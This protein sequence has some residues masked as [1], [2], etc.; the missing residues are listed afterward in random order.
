MLYQRTGVVLPLFEAPAKYRRGAWLAGADRMR[1]LVGGVGLEVQGRGLSWRA[2]YTSASSGCVNR[3][4][5]PF[6]T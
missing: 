4:F 3:A 5:G 1:L 2:V 6:R